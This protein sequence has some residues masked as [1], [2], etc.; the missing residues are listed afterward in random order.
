MIIEFDFYG[1]K[2]VK[3]RIMRP[4]KYAGHLRPLFNNLADFFMDIEIGQFASDGARGSRPWKPLKPE[5]VR[6]KERAGLDPRILRA[7]G[8]LYESLTQRGDRDQ[9]LYIMEDFMIFGS[10]VEYGFFHQNAR[11]VP[12]RRPIEFTEKDRRETV[13]KIQRYI[14]TGG[15]G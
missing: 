12:R 6:R 1:E 4:G 3:R 11:G 15:L 8:A 13:K 9:K 7:T 2:Q 14:L 5:T 10:K